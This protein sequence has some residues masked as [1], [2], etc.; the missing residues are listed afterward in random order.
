MFGGG[1]GGGGG[2]AQMQHWCYIPSFLLSSTPAEFGSDVL[3]ILKGKVAEF[4]MITRTVTLGRRSAISEVD[5]DLSLEGPAFK[6]SRKQVSG[7]H[8]V[9]GLPLLCAIN[10][11]CVVFWLC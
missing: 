7:Q 5:F 6:V 1:G 8:L 2:L 9:R 3:A 4:L 10:Y 11:S